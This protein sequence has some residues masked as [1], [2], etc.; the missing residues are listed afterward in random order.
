MLELNFFERM[1]AGIS[2]RMALNRYMARQAL[3]VA[4]AYDGASRGRRMAVGEHRSASGDLY[5]P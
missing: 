4:L 1:I 3:D 2:P 5:S